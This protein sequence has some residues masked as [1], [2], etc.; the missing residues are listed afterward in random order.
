MPPKAENLKNLDDLLA[1]PSID[2]GPFEPM[3]QPTGANIDSTVPRALQL[4][5][6]SGADQ[7]AVFT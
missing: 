2:F 7:G 3:F 1:Q 5:F 6:K 4:V